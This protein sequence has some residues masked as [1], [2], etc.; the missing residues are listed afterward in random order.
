MTLF[1]ARLKHIR[2]QRQFICDKLTAFRHQ[3][4]RS[5]FHHYYEH[6]MILPWNIISVFAYVYQPMQ[7]MAKDP[8][9]FT[10]TQTIKPSFASLHSTYKLE[11]SFKYK[12]IRCAIFEAS[13]GKINFIWHSV[14]SVWL[15]HRLLITFTHSHSQCIHWMLKRML[16][17]SF[18]VMSRDV[19]WHGQP[20]RNARQSM[21]SR[22]EQRNLEI[23]AWCC[24]SN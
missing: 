7:R 2:L 22:F 5:G 12:M 8:I 15:S 4:D 3:F 18:G 6:E 20:V 19:C 1:T 9:W 10:I 23:S 24:R 16:V 14:C 21:D 17:V 11:N 13:Q